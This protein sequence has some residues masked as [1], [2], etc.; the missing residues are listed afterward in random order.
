MVPSLIALLSAFAY[1]AADFLGG[2]ASH[3]ANALAV[4]I[5]SQA[6]GLILLAAF[7]ILVSR[8]LPDRTDLMWGMVAGFA[9]GGGVVLLY[10][11]LAIGPMSIVAPVTA[12][13]AALIPVA[14]G[15]AR[16]E[17]LTPQTMTA[18]AL[19]L[20]A[21]VLVGQEPRRGAATAVR[22][23]GLRI[24]LASGVLIGIFLATLAGASPAAGLWPLIPARVA[25]IVMVTGI[26]AATRRSMRVPSPALP[27]AVGGGVLDMLANAL[28]LVA[29]HRGPL[30]L[31]ATLASLYPA[32]TIV[33]AHL[34]LGERLSA[35]Q[36]AGIAC[37]IVA[38]VLL[39]SG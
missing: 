20:A 22:W 9:G 35:L 27:A 18:I 38:T 13:C 15:M 29:V 36:L 6:A 39:V 14:V 32:S 10:R 2:I 11:A 28:Y 33:L 24:A 8:S 37:A 30:S 31:M 25:S 19:A 26:A 34:F 21:I 23:D 4:V 1:G 16:G 5:V 17:R 12:V 7:L 3:R